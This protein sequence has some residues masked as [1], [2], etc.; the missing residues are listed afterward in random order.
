MA[1]HAC[2]AYALCSWPECKGLHD[3]QQT[4]LLCDLRRLHHVED[5]SIT[6]LNSVGYIFV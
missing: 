5:G 4:R 1:I 6:F 3:T 2:V